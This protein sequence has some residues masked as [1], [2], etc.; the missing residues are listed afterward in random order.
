M[1]GEILGFSLPTSKLNLTLSF[2]SEVFEINVKKHQGNSCLFSIFNLE[3]NVFASNQSQFQEPQ[4]FFKFR[5]E[6]DE[7]SDL[8]KKME[9]FL[10]KNKEFE[11][12]FKIEF[13]ECFNKREKI[14]KVIDPDNRIWT[15]IALYQ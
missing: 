7:I 1:N 4:D 12:F 15:F 2:I 3:V 9:L 14:L 8:K 5:C 13:E 6:V 10:Y 11:K